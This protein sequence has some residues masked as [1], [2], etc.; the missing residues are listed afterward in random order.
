[1]K[2]INKY[3]LSC[4]LSAMLSVTFLGYQ[5]VSADTTDKWFSGFTAP[6][7]A[8]GVFSPLPVSQ[9]GVRLKDTNSDIYVKI[10]SANY[11]VYVQTFALA[12]KSWTGGSNQ[13]RNASGNPVSYVSLQVNTKYHI[14]NDVNSHGQYAGLRMCTANL[15]NSDTVNGLW[16]PDYTYDPNA[17]LAN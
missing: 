2:R 4:A 10:T 12:Q 6:P 14:K 17:Q 13:T 9:N 3:V 8:S 1:M 15:Y 7:G 11:N 5:S 16:S